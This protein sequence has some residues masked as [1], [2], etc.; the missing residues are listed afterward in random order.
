MYTYF[1]V[2][3]REL[4]LKAEVIVS[5]IVIVK[6]YVSNENLCTVDIVK[7]AIVH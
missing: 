4:E 6:T 1:S 7:L 2:W 5:A 3:L